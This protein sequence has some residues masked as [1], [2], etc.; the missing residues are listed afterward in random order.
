MADKKDHR[1]V[2]RDEEEARNAA[3]QK[4]VDKS[5]A[6]ATKE[7]EDRLAEQAKYE[8]T[9]IRTVQGKP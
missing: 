9:G 2:A 1:Q 6:E 7:A 5:N 4:A 3:V 8:T